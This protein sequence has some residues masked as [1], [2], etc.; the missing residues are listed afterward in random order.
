MDDND[1]DDFAN[2]EY[3]RMIDDAENDDDDFAT[4]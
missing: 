1:D 2:N 3:I 4:N